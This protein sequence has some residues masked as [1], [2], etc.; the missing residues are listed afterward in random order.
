MTRSNPAMT[1]I[2][3]IHDAIEDRLEMMEYRLEMDVYLLRN[4]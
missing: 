3:T 4:D 1:P 2:K